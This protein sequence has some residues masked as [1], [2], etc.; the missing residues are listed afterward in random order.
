[1]SKAARRGVRA[2]LANLA[3]GARRVYESRATSMNTIMWEGGA[4]VAFAAVEWWYA[5][6]GGEWVIAGVPV[7][8]VLGLA[9]IG[10]GAW[11]VS[12]GSGTMGR[13]A[14]TGGRAFLLS[15]V[16]SMARERGAQSATPAVGASPASGTGW[17]PR[18]AGQLP[19][20]MR[21]Q[22]QWAGAARVHAAR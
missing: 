22:T 9:G 3:Q 14:I 20:G 19:D 7:A 5:Y 21:G 4:V 2:R 10:L 16:G 13:A 6:M 11:L 15:W 12:R 8:P 17:R 1:M 18:H